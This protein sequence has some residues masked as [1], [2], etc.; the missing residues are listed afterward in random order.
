MLAL[1]PLPLIQFILGPLVQLVR[2]KWRRAGGWWIVSI[3]VSVIL[4][5]TVLAVHATSPD[6]GLQETERYS[7]DGWYLIG[8]W[9]TYLTGV[10]MVV[11]AIGR[12]V[13]KRLHAWLFPPR[14]ITMP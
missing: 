7:F 5:V 9:G 6:L 11:V 2:G 13:V 1:A 3:G 12:P 14:E 8:L 10:I 4:A